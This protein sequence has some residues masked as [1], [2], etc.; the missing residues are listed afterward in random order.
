MISSTSQ[1]LTFGPFTLDLSSDSLWRDGKA[2]PLRPQALRLLKALVSHSGLHLDHEQMIRQAWDNVR[3]SK[4][5]VTVTMGEV[6]R[7][8]GEYGAWIRCHPRLGYCIEIPESEELLRTGWHHLNRRTREGLE[9][10]VRCFEQAAIS[11]GAEGRAME[12]ASRAYLLMGSFGMRSPQD[13][14][15]K[16]Q[17]A[18]RRVVELRG[19]T[20]ELRV[21]L[22]MGLH[23]FERRFV[24]AESI[25]LKAIDEQPRLASA[26]LRLAMLYA[27]LQRQSESME[28]LRRARAADALGPGLAMA[29]ILVHMDARDFEAAAEHGRRAMEL[30]PHFPSAVVFYAWALEAM[31]KY[32]QALEQYRMSCVLAPDIMWH[33]ILEAACMAKMGRI[34]DARAISRELNKLRGYEYV[35]PYHNS[36]LLYALGD[37]DEAFRELE[38]AYEISC[39]TLTM[40]DV[41]AKLD[42]MRGDPRFAAVRAKVFPG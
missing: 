17:A 32:Q 11:T 12:G 18:H 37:K 9:K 19:Y 21:D 27:S 38:Q 8:L 3:V 20:P 22:A 23:L 42:P 29:E 35:D 4:H 7:A 34:D 16:F 24:E 26:Y 2:L 10:A 36:I 25:L 31:G 41:D 33:R 30:H 39:P 28:M 15:P 14:Y 6:K 5:T 13:T 1:I 40:I